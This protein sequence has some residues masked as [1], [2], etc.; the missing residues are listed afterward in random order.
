MAS[1]LMDIKRHFYSDRIVHYERFIDFLHESHHIPFI[2]YASVICPDSDECYFYLCDAG[3]STRSVHGI[4]VKVSVIQ[5][6]RST[7]FD[8]DPM[9]DAVFSHRYE[10]ETGVDSLLDNQYLNQYL[11]ELF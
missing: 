8:V 1:L 4:W 7:G 3:Y 5:D 9:L 2:V 10:L 6:A 11:D